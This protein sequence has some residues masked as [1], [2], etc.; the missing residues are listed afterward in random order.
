MEGVEA[1][2]EPRQ[3]TAVMHFRRGAWVSDGRT[4][5]NMTPADALRLHAREYSLVAHAT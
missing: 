5:F 1:A 4:L 2:T 3:A